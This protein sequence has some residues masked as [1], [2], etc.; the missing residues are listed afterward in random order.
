MAGG[1]G[2]R[3][4][5]ADGDVVHPLVSAVVVTP[6]PNSATPLS[7]PLSLLAYPPR[8]A[9][10]RS[11]LPF[12]PVPLLTHFLVSTASSFSQPSSSLPATGSHSPSTRPSP[13][14]G[15]PTSPLF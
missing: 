3:R 8:K 10:V 5:S 12:L 9:L 6:A 2:A 7:S 4:F 13:S 15:L 11:Q 1:N 14:P